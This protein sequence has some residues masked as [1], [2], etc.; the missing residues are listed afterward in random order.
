VPRGY[1]PRAQARTASLRPAAACEHAS[2]VAAVADHSVAAHG[3][4]ECKG[5]LDRGGGEGG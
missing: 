3:S 5:A 4:D 2:G 1:A